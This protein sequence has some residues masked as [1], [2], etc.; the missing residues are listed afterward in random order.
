L[1]QAT[2]SL[3]IGIAVFAFALTLW[4]F[5]VFLVRKGI[6]IDL[7]SFADSVGLKFDSGFY[8]FSSPRISGLYEGYPIKI[9]YLRPGFRSR[10]TYLQVTV[11]VENRT[12]AYLKLVKTWIDNGRLFPEFETGDENFDRKVNIVDSPAGFGRAVLASKGLRR[13]LLWFNGFWI[14][15]D[16]QTLI[17]RH[18]DYTTNAKL[19]RKIL[20]VMCG[21]ADA[22]DLVEAT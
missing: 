12:N 16:K 4:S 2:G 15:L 10:N 1:N 11:S 14:T 21:L 5:F 20:D 22:I 9:E 6:E 7:H 18:F 3:L 13:Q 17:F 19:L 8:P